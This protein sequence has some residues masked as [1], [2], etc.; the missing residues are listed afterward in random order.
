MFHADVVLKCDRI[1]SATYQKSTEAMILTKRCWMKFTL[2]SSMFSS[3]LLLCAAPFN[4]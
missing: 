2:Q 4:H 3:L 1:L